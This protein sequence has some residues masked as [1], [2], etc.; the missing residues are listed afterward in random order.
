MA[1]KTK[2]MFQIRRIIQLHLQG[3]SRSEIAR[4]LGIA[5]NTVRHYLD[6]FIEHVHPLSDALSWTDEALFRFISVKPES[7]KESHRVLYE[8][9]KTFESEL[10][11]TGVS[12][13]RLWLEYRQEYPKGLQFSQFCY[14]FRQWQK[15]QQVVMRLEHKAGEKLF[16]DWAGDRLY[17]TDAQTGEKTA[18]EVFVAIL[19]CSQL[20]FVKAS[21]TQRKPDFLSVLADALTFFGGVPQAIIPDNMKTAVVKAHRYDPLINES[22]EHFAAH[23]QTCIFPTRSGKPKDKALVENAVHLTYERIYAPLRNQTFYSLEALNAAITLLL[24]AHNQALFQGKDYSRRSRFEAIEKQTLQPLPNTRY[25]LQFYGMAKVHPD[26]HALLS[27]DKHYYS[28]PYQL[29]GERVKFI[30]TATSVEIYHNYKRVACHER[31]IAKHH[32]TTVKEHLPPQHQYM[33][34][35]SVLFFESESLKIGENTH[36]A[37]AQLLHQRTYPAQ[38]FKTCAGLLSMA[39][40]VSYERME[41]ACERALGYNSLS[42]TLIKSILDRELDR[43]DLHHEIIVPTVII[44]HENLRGAQAYQ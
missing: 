7:P 29:I 8:R 35:W 34:N 14:L 23:Y 44:Q 24:E 3:T 30:Y 2:A 31:I 32:Y 42:Y 9:F 28:V 10:S 19:A 21:P 27:E 40:K 38:A 17:L 5:R 6:S 41:R 26:C 15:N 22:L 25:Q 37:F 43:L 18:V 1:N 39:K 33:M 4:G 16:V 20:T 11:R 13:Q 12:R 36:L